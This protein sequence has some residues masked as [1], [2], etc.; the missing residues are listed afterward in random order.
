MET[1][2]LA[3]AFLSIF[4][5]NASALTCSDTKNTVEAVE[6]CVNAVRTMPDKWTPLFENCQ[7]G[8]MDPAPELIRDWRLQSAADSHTKDM[9]ASSR[10]SH[11]G[12]DG[13]FVTE[14]V[15]DRAGFE[16][17]Y[18]GENVAGGF[19]SAFDVV[20]AWMCSEGHRKAI[21]N[22]N[23]NVVG[24]GVRCNPETERCFFTQDF[25]CFP[26]NS[27][28]C[29]PKPAP[30]SPP[31]PPPPS[32]PPPPPPSPPPRSPPPPPPRPPPSPKPSPSPSP[33]PSTPKPSPPPKNPPPPPP[34]PKPKPVP[35]P[36]SFSRRRFRGSNG[37]YY[38][39]LG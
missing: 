18:I 19:N 4:F 9:A 36:P 16:G 20:A 12:N 1:I 5:Q 38:V 30:K 37:V 31:P 26:R 28:S 7:L 3:V 14:R 8:S 21:M 39:T 13:S 2:V 34:S 15:V 33:K 17:N 10:T 22:C 35:S 32:P 23:H 27:C 6:E 11:Y 29:N 25:G 24:T